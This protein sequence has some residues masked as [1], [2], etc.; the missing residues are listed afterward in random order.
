MFA[1]LGHSIATLVKTKENGGKASREIKANYLQFQATSS[2][3]GMLLRVMI[4]DTLPR[5]FQMSHFKHTPRVIPPR[6][7]L[8]VTADQAYARKV[9]QEE[10][11]FICG[12]CQGAM[13]AG[14]QNFGDM[15]KRFPWETYVV[16][17]GEKLAATMTALN[18]L[19]SLDS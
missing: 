7:Y 19:Q 9:A 4:F 2:G 10:V 16:L 5:Q 18:M 3:Q 12:H 1:P 14:Y 15:A 13:M 17:T 8:R 11:V 6:S